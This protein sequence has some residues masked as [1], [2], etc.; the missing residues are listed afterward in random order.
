MKS[1][2]DDLLTSAS[3]VP[4]GYCLLWR[5]DLVALH[6]VSDGAVALSYF[7]IPLVMAYFL[8][9]RPDI[10]GPNKSIAWLFV[11]FI[12]ACGITHL[13]GL[14][15][16]WW[17][18]YGIQGLAKAGTAIMSVTTVA[19]MIYALPLA[20]RVPSVAQLEAANAELRRLR[21]ELATSA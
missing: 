13:I 19:A 15:M 2:I 4:H 14:V 17:P 8:R 11:V 9:K 6:A 1:V 18:I 21:D 20:L 7:A 3:F 10:A 16:M 5:P 12:L